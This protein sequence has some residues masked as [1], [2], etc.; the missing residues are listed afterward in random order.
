MKKRLTLGLLASTLAFLVVPPTAS[1]ATLDYNIAFDA[2]KMECGV[3]GLQVICGQSH[4]ITPVRTFAGDIINIHFASAQPVVV[5]ASRVGIG[6]F[7]LSAFDANAT[8]GPQG[9]G[10]IRTDYNMSA[11][12]LVGRPLDFSFGTVSRNTDYI[13]VMGY[14]VPNTGFSI[15][16]ADAVLKV[17]N[18]DIKDIIGISSGYYY[19]LESAPVTYNDLVGGTASS[20]LI[21]PLG[22]ISQINGVIGGEGPKDQFYNFNWNG[23]LFQSLGNVTGA[24]LTDTFAYELFDAS[25]TKLESIWLNDANG[26]SQLMTRNLAAGHYTIGLAANAPV[27]PAFMLKFLTPVGGVPEPTTWAMMILGFGIIGVNLRRRR[28]VSTV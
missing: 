4:A 25:N 27:D 13:G 11:T 12:G 17:L 16:G 2:A 21:L 22:Y 3:F 9:P 6:G 20:P 15:T 18:A 26:F 23:G 14:G 10:P 28:V 24:A 1:A 5:P 19:Q 8:F 7:Y